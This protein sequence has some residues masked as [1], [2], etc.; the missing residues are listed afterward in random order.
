MSRR[1][2]FWFGWALALVAIAGFARLGFWQYGRMQE[3]QALLAN[4]ERVLRNPAPVALDAPGTP[5]LAWVEG[6]ATIDARTLLLDNQQRD[7]TPGVHVYC[8]AHAGSSDRAGRPGVDR[9]QAR[10]HDARSGLSRGS[11]AHPRPDDVAA[12]ERPA[13]GRGLAENRRFTLADGAR[14]CRCDLARPLGVAVAPRVI[15]LDPKLPVG[16]A[17][18]L[19]MLPNT[20]P[21]E[22]HLGYAV[23][24]WAL[25]LAVFI[26]ALVLSIRKSKPNA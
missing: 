14:G 12:F 6:P 7:G 21:P 1:G 20:L 13:H 17:R 24:W 5:G 22:R 16:Y 19:N 26:T 11:A 8:I 9:G 25:S 2:T 18:D 3:K 4:V 15:R 10:S 23:Q